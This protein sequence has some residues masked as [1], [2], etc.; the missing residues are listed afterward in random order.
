MNPSVPAELDPVE[1]AR[2]ASGPVPDPDV[3]DQIGAAG[4]G[5]RRATRRLLRVVLDADPRWTGRLRFDAFRRA[6]T[7]D[8]KPLRDADLTRMSC[9][10]EEVYQAAPSRDLLFEVASCVAEDHAFHPVRDWLDGLVWDGVERAPSLL[11]RML[12]AA[13]TPL[14]AEMGRAFLV[15]AVARVFEPG[16]KLD[17][18]LVLVGKQGIGKSQVCRALVPE[19][20]WF[21]DTPLDLRSKD[22]YQAL[23]GKW[24]V[25]HAEM[26]SVR[27]RSATRVKSFLSSATDSF[28]APYAR[29]PED[30][31]RQCV[32]IGTPN[33]PEL[34]DDGS[35]SRRFWPV[36][37][38][39]VQP[40]AVAAWRDQ[41]WAEAVVRY[42]RGERWHLDAAAEAERATAAERFHITDPVR[43][44]M[45]AWLHRTK[46]PFSTAEA[47]SEG[48]GVGVEAIDRSLQ[49]RIGLLLHELGC[50]KFRLR[51]SLGGA[52]RWEPPPIGPQGAT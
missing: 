8:G 37:V 32:F 3:V 30:H 14:H 50:S 7:L 38:S 15:G 20:S 43:E 2:V 29:A 47:L 48:L 33:H 46:G 25:E 34:F 36:Q 11:A 13:P 16:V 28:R 4:P 9:W 17:T 10:V 12:G 27:G 52:W 6:V 39:W 1:L 18:M 51:R 24:I 31:P 42:R 45:A 40:Q 19:A 41:L 5:G 21:S 22:A 23:H 49:T 44:R 35:G 26:E